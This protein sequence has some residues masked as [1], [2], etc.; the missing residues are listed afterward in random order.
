MLMRLSQVK[1]LIRQAITGE[2]GHFDPAIL[3]LLSNVP[4]GFIRPG[5]YVD[6]EPDELRKN[7][8]E[9]L[10]YASSQGPGV[11]TATVSAA[12]RSGVCHYLWL[13]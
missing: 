13:C 9:L 11:N 8:E 7:V 10:F 6:V 5:G 4:L 1:E 12:M 2:G 3:D